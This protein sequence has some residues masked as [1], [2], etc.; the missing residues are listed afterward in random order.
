[1][2]GILGSV[3]FKTPSNTEGLIRELKRV[4]QVARKTVNGAAERRIHRIGISVAG[5]VEP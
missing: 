5:M 1:M 2:S 4:L 3:R